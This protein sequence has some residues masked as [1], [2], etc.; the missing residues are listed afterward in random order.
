MG[1]AAVGE[2]EVIGTDL[3]DE[4]EIEKKKKHSWKIMSWYYKLDVLSY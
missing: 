1:K 2:W 4:K 3:E